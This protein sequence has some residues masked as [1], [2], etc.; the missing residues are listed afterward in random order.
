M[1]KSR[2]KAAA[3]FVAR[4]KQKGSAFL[5]KLKTFPFFVKINKKG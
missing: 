4:K 5:N 2:G 3:L 1:K